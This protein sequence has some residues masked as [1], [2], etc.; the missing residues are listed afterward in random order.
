MIF[1]AGASSNQNDLVEKEVILSGGK[2]LESYL[3]GVEFESD[4]KTAYSFA[5]NTHCATRLLLL[6]R[7]KD[8]INNFD[9]FYKESLDMEWEKYL[10]PN[11]TFMISQTTS[12]VKWIKNTHYIELKFKD[13]IVERLRSVYGQRPDVDRD[14]PDVCFHI[15]IKKDEVFWYL[16]FGGKGFS[17]RGYRKAETT[18]VM[19]E[20][21]AASVLYRS[22]WYKD[23]CK[24]F[25]KN[26]VLLDPFC[27]SGTICIEAALICTNTAPGLINSE[28]FGFLKLP[29]HDERLW[30]DVIA[31]AKEKITP[32]HVRIIG[33]DVSDTAIEISK[34]NTELANL[35]DYITF[36]KKD[37]SLLNE[38]DVSNLS[39]GMTELDMAESGFY[40]VTDPPYGNRLKTDSFFYSMIG[41]TLANFF[42]GW[43]VSIICGNSE[44]LS[45]IDMKPNR[46]NVFI[47]GGTE[48][49]LAH[50]YVFTEKE[51][52]DMAERALKKKSERIS[53]PLS[54]GAQMIFNRLVKN[55]SALEKDLKEKNITCYRLYDADMPEY[56][57]AVDVYENKWIN[58]QEYAPPKTI[59]PEASKRRLEEAVLATERATGVDMENIFIKKR[60]IQKGLKQYS[61]MNSFNKFNIIHEG[62]FRFCVNFTDN[63]DTGIFLD[64]RP[65]RAIIKNESIKK[66]FLNLFCYTGTATVYASAGGALSTV[67]VDSSNYYLS[68]AKHNMS[69]NGFTSMNHFYYKSDVFDYLLSNKD[70]FD[71]IYCDPPTFSNSKNR[72]MFDIQKDHDY[73]I[74]TCV[75]HLSKDGILIFSTNYTKFRLSENLFEDFQ[76]ED[77]TDTTIDVD[78]LRHKNIHKCFL[79]KHGNKPIKNK[80]QVRFKLK[81]LDRLS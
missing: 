56:S 8:Q 77:I 36:E 70:V 22:P 67:S 73:L 14:N 49:Q 75:K 32:T 40:M 10:N 26:M 5:L 47:S 68:W 58:L 71:L 19:S 60:E 62:G 50:Y 43:N 41:S 44:L 42:K 80:R 1:F 34:N 46:I 59:D 16:D 29:F 2:V 6:L 24:D 69:L 13:A 37:F 48:C 20:Y 4:L 54:S 53:S 61:K 65:L 81:R 74:R 38:E 52:K 45:N 31:E 76:I 64:H 17:H 33:W 63:L 72:K 66:R 27:G 7:K 57:V 25:T 11:Q 51:R 9:D 3:G 18:A 55:K 15:H 12:D 21:L 39:K 23:L 28:R 35:S 79:I 78:F 30:N